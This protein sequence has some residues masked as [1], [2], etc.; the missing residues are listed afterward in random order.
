MLSH[1]KE[2]AKGKLSVLQSNILLVK[3]HEL[4]KRFLYLPLCPPCPLSERQF[5]LEKN[6]EMCLGVHLPRLFLDDEA[7]VLEKKHKL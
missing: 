6:L 3:Q 1:G 7:E 2:N 4:L 5:L